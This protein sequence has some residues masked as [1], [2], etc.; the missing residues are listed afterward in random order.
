M[1]K[2]NCDYNMS[3]N[4]TYSYL[5]IVKS[6]HSPQLWGCKLHFS[7]C[8]TLHHLPSSTWIINEGKKI[9]MQSFKQLTPVWSGS[10]VSPSNFH[11]LGPNPSRP[12]ASEPEGHYT[13]FP[14]NSA[15]FL[16]SNFLSENFLLLPSPS[17]PGLHFLPVELQNLLDSG[18]DSPYKQPRTAVNSVSWQTLS[19]SHLPQQQASAELVSCAPIVQPVRLAED[20]VDIFLQPGS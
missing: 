9:Q 10:T 20:S 3:T 12:E 11:Q 7:S 1:V 15:H 19:S 13:A 16:G 4:S 2:T 14:C 6:I 5:Y 18:G 8:S 17:F